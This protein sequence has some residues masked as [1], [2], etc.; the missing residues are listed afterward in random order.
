[1][2]E[3]DI[4]VGD[5]RNV[6]TAGS[7]IEDYPDDEP[8]PSRLVLGWVGGRPIHVVMAENRADDELIVVTAYV[9]D[10]EQ[11]DE[12]FTRRKR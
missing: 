2:F 12:K 1:M 5:V 7:V 9:P 6:I 10:P 11:W 8:Y 3:R 4:T